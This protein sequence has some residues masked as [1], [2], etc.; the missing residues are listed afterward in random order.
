MHSI[1]LMN[2]SEIFHQEPCGLLFFAQLFHKHNDLFRSGGGDRIFG[3]KIQEIPK[4]LFI[5][6]TLYR[7]NGSI[8]R[9]VSTLVR[10]G[11]GTGSIGVEQLN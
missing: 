10:I 11:T 7:R 2:L 4:P 5:V 9:M 3:A 8:F 6:R 1:K